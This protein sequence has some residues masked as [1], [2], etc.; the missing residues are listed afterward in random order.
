ML[1]KL[2]AEN[3]ATTIRFSHTVCEDAVDVRAGSDETI[4]K[5]AP[6]QLAAATTK[7]APDDARGGVRRSRCEE[8]DRLAPDK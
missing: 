1:A 5:K 6:G 7:T 2:V 8:N 3:P 4:L